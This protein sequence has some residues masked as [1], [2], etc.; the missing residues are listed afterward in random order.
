MTEP[1]RDNG[2]LDYN[3]KE[4]SLL[5]HGYVVYIKNI[6]LLKIE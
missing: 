2:W 3:L 4:D 1:R 6:L 5:A